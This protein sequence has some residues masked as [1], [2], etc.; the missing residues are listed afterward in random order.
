MAEHFQDKIHA[1]P[2]F[3]WFFYKAYLF[4]VFYMICVHEPF[5]NAY[6]KI[7]AKKEVFGIP[8]TKTKPCAIFTYHSYMH[9][10]F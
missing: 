8:L 5:V 4:Y 10:E 7:F 2:P 3:S 9:Y 6:F 1:L